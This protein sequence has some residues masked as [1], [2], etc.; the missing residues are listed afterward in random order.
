MIS[1]LELVD[2]LCD[3]VS[4]E[5]SADGRQDVEDHL[6]NCATCLA[7]HRSYSAVIRLTR[8][9]PASPLP[10]GLRQRLSALGGNQPG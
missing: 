8:H 9:L 3:F 7:L 1:C 5:L 10:P 2:L 6:Q 4:G